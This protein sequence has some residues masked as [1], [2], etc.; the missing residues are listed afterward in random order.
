VGEHLLDTLLGEQRF[1][2][3]ALAVEVL[4]RPLVG[5]LGDAECRGADEGPRHLEG[6][7]RAG[8]ARL[9]AFAAALQL[10]LQLLLAAEQV[11]SG[12]AAILEHDLS[13][14]RG[15]D[16]ELRLLLALGQ[17]RRPLADDER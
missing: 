3:F 11:L 1:A 5:G 12:D 8:A 2:A 6:G 15:T 17:A 9:L 13:R 10:A 4:K 7:E 16:A 14:V